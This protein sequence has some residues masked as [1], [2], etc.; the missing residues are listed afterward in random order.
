M[1]LSFDFFVEFQ[2]TIKKYETTIVY[3]YIDITE[4]GTV[5]V[6]F[7]KKATIDELEERLLLCNICIANILN[8]KKFCMAHKGGRSYFRKNWEQ[9]FNSKN[10]C[11]AYIDRPLEMK[12]KIETELIRRQDNNLT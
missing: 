10:P 4:K 8:F 1:S 12:N 7:L 2:E 3:S 11:F 5:G 9:C 6:K